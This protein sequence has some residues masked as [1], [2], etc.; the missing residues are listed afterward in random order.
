MAEQQT[1]ALEDVLADFERAK[2]ELLSISE[3]LRSFD[4]IAEQREQERR[5]LVASSA[6]LT[7][8][9]KGLQ[10]IV[11][12]LQAAVGSVTSVMHT[13]GAALQATDA[14]QLVERLNGIE[15]LVR[16]AADGQTAVQTE[17]REGLGEQQQTLQRTTGFFQQL[18]EPTQQQLSQL[19]EDRS[20]RE[21]LAAEN[22]ELRAKLDLV[23]SNLKPRQLETMG[24]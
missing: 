16:S 12:E 7:G 2:G 14:S 1:P 5:T 23:R 22:A 9:A 19:A 20:E 13:A 6:E 11:A 17:V 4:A 3:K 15:E 8:T 24:L 21:R 10:E 18:L